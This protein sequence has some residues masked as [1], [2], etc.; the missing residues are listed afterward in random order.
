[1]DRI[2]RKQHVELIVG[3]SE[4]TLRRMEKAGTFPRRFPILPDKPHGVCGWL[5]SEV[6]EWVQNRIKLRGQLQ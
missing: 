2:L 4:R 3:L 1:M 5:E 6:T